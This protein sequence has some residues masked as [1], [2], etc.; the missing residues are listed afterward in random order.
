MGFND[1]SAVLHPGV[2]QTPL[3]IILKLLIA[4]AITTRVIV[5]EGGIGVAHT[6]EFIVP[7][8]QMIL[9]R[10]PSHSH[11]EDQQGE[12]CFHYRTSLKPADCTSS[13]LE[14]VNTLKSP[15]SALYSISFV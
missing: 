6:I 14:P 10:S 5:P 8:Q 12:K 11:Q 3:R 15:G 9:S 2:L 7:Y 4:P 13:E 1:Q